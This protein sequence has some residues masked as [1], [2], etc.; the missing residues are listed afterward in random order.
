M[1]HWQGFAAGHEVEDGRAEAARRLTAATRRP[2]R[3]QSNSTLAWKLK[4]RDR[5]VRTPVGF[6]MAPE[7]SAPCCTH[8]Q[9]GRQRRL[10][11]CTFSKKL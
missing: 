8:E 10:Q 11:T 1:R 4:R 6:R 5:Q 3:W 7:S 2:R 9:R